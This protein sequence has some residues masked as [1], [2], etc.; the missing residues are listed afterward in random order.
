MEAKLKDD[1]TA[2]A[3][4]ILPDELTVPNVEDPLLLAPKIFPVVVVCAAPKIEP[5]L[6]PNVDGDC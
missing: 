6:D 4:N 2:G 1:D 5:V 3:P